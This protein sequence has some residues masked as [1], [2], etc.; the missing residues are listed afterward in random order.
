MRRLIERPGVRLL[1]DG[2][3]L[4][5]ASFDALDPC[6]LDRMFDNFA[7]A[8]P[9][10]DV[11]EMVGHLLSLTRRLRQAGSMQ[12]W[13]LG[14]RHLARDEHAVVALIAA[15]QSHNDIRAQEIVANL[16]RRDIHGVHRPGQRIAGLLEKAGLFIGA[17]TVPLDTV[18]GHA[19]V[20]CA[21][22]RCPWHRAPV[23]L[24]PGTRR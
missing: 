14:C 1:V 12:I 23:P 17:V 3:R 7:G 8:M 24:C 19:P 16:K 13:P 22:P 6:C 11:D 20:D 15:F 2:M 18:A 4:A 5:M 21:T 10:Q 9:E